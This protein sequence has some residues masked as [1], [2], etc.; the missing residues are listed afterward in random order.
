MLPFESSL[1]VIDILR[2]SINTARLQGVFGQVLQLSEPETT[3][4]FPHG[5]IK[6]L[7]LLRSNLK[8]VYIYETVTALKFDLMRLG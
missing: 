6:S 8:T 3:F 1:P 2:Q 4:R 5:Q 7:V